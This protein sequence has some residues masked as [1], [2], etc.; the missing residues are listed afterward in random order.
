MTGLA[1]TLSGQEKCGIREK[2]IQGE[3]PPHYLLE[4]VT[5]CTPRPPCQLLPQAVDPQHWICKWHILCKLMSYSLPPNL[6]A[7]GKCCQHLICL[8]FLVQCCSL[9]NWRCESA[10]GSP[11]DLDLAHFPQTPSVPGLGISHPFFLISLAGLWEGGEPCTSITGCCLALFLLFCKAAKTQ[12][13][14]WRHQ[15]PCVPTFRESHISLLYGLKEDCTGSSLSTLTPGGECKS[16]RG[17][18]RGRGSNCCVAGRSTLH[19]EFILRQD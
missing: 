14:I 16:S 17:G 19:K 10:L 1:P 2:L 11:L 12:N 15:G 18:G 7:V 5:I 9:R 6:G 3:L 8:L 13:W 4:L